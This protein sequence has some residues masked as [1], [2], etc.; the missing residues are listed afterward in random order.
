[1]DCPQV[2][3]RRYRTRADCLVDDLAVASLRQSSDPFA[4]R[5]AR[6]S[7]RTRSGPSAANC[8]T[9]VRGEASLAVGNASE[10]PAPINVLAQTLGDIALNDT[11]NRRDV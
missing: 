7:A 5:V 11:C 1:M 6:P 10:T 8:P 3:R 4:L 9:S 2:C